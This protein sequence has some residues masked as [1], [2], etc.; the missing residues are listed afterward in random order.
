MDNKDF[1]KLVELLEKES[2]ARIA[3][4]VARA[5]ETAAFQQT[6]SD[7]NASFGQ[8][9]Q[10]LNAT[11]VQL[12][13]TIGRLLEENRLLKGPKKNSGNSSIAP[14]KDENRPQRTSSLRG[15]SGKSSGGQKGHEG[16]TLKMSAAPDHVVEHRPGFC[17]CCG[18]DLDGQQGELAS[19]RQVIDIPVIRPSYTEHRIFRKACTC[20]HI[21]SGTFPSGVE[22]PISYGE[23]T[24]ALIAYLHTRQYI[25][26]ARISEFFSSVYGMGISQGTVCGIIDRFAQKALPAF[27]LIKQAISNAKVIGAD[28][29]GMK[30]NGKL[31]WFWSWQSKF[32]T[33]I[34]ASKNRGFETVKA[35]FPSGF[36]NAILVHDCWPSHFNTPADGHQICTVH[37]LREL[38]FFKEK[39]QCPWAVQ[40]SQM[41]MQ[42]IELK[43]TIKPAD[44][45]NPIP[46]RAAIEALL[47]E[48]IRQQI[49]PDQPE[50]ITF[51]KR[52]IKHRAYL[53]TFLYH[54]QVPS[55]N[56]SSEQ[57]IRNVKVKMKVSGMFKS[58]KGAQNYAIIRS[59][60]DTCKKN[61]QE[62]LNA[63]FTIASS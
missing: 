38:R 5:A 43:K 2:S 4:E 48:L 7:Q 19:R 47:D 35:H 36:P 37:L 20:G 34:T 63:F 45:G 40:F 18:L 8:T 28:E 61:Q 6:I 26:L 42:A 54:H 53:L 58:A 9:I 56:N 49:S 16:S 57:A 11:I 14:S 33:Y 46:Q 30:E 10:D 1:L 3:A 41:I 25:P 32:A 50:V 21:T 60:T 27:A 12:N 51:H 55:H 44:Y 29:T 22:A 23:Q 52:I 15:S 59:I 13:E 31:N 39:Y 62:I 24:T 17:N